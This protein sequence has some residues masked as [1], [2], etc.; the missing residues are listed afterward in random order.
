MPLGSGL[1]AEEQVQGK[2]EY[3]GLQ[4]EVFPLKKKSFESKNR[5]VYLGSRDMAVEGTYARASI[6][7]QALG[8]GGRIR[9]EIYKDRFRLEE[10]TSSIQNAAGCTCVIR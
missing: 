4:I 6:P 10:G 7:D 1:S 8:P 3:G 5:R 9:E 2:A